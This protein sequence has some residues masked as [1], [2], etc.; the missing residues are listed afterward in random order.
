MLNIATFSI[1]YT[2]IYFNGGKSQHPSFIALPVVMPLTE[3][4]TDA[5]VDRLEGTVIV[6]ENNFLNYEVEVVVNSDPCP[7]TVF[8]TFQG[9]SITGGDMYTFNLCCVWPPSLY[10]HS[11]YCKPV[12]CYIWEIFCYFCKPSWLCQ[13]SWFIDFNSK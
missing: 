12:C 9:F 6:P 7:P 1:Q 4:N 5:H 3:S 10:L 11:H 2:Y 13:S 8:W